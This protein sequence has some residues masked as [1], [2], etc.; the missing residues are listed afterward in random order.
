[1]A[2]EYRVVEVNASY[3]L[4]PMINQW[5]KHNF[6]PYGIHSIVKKQIL[7]DHPIVVILLILRKV[8]RKKRKSK[9]QEGL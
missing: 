9:V 3:E 5:A 1:M 8:V 7:A 2:Y 4:E 6:E